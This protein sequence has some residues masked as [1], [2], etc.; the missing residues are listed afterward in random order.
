MYQMKIV[1]NVSIQ[2]DTILFWSNMNLTILIS[3]FTILTA[4]PSCIFFW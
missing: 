3:F 4:L 2:Y 1:E